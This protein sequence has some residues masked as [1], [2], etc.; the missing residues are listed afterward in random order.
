MQPGYQFVP[1][2]SR[3]SIKSTVNNNNNKSVAHRL[4]PCRV[5]TCVT[6]VSCVT[7]CTATELKLTIPHFHCIL[8]RQKQQTNVSAYSVGPK[9][10]SKLVVIITAL[11]RVPPVHVAEPG[12]EQ[13][14]RS[15]QLAGGIRSSGNRHYARALFELLKSCKCV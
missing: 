5:C 3:T 9:S 1:R 2:F 12:R 10:H 13:A 8:A 14:G 4:H 7:N 11:W 15:W 6:D